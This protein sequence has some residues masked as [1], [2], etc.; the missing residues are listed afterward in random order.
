MIELR[1]APHFVRAPERSWALWGA[2]TQLPC[3]AVP[4]EPNHS[5]E[6]ARSDFR[7]HVE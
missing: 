5:L 6:Q 2:A 3:R 1:L 7:Q 4:H